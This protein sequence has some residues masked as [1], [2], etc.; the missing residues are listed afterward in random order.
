MTTVDEVRDWLGR[1]LY[2]E[3]HEKVGSITDIYLDDATGEPEWLA[4]K[5][6]L[7]GMNVSFVPI[8]GASEMEDHVMV[9]YTKDTVKDAPNVDSDGELSPEQE[10]R[11]YEHY[12]IAFGTVDAQAFDAPVG[13]DTSG[14]NTDTAMTRSEEEMVVGSRERE[15][16]RARLRKYIVTEEVQQRVPVSREEVRIEREPITDANI[17]E[18]LAGPALHEEEHEVTLYEEEP[19][20]EKRVVPKE[21]VRLE[22]EREVGEET[23]EGEIRKEQIEAE[24]DVRRR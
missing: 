19:V 24:G 1:E 14:P 17:D 15:T 13:H 7:F 10:R 8:A 5:T 2:G 11:L 3:G 23:V 4:V 12:E 20:V 9:P 16:G 18:A 22:K 6:G 21:R